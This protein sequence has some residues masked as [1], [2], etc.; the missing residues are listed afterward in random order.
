M[1]HLKKLTQ[2][3]AADPWGTYKR[4]ASIA[5]GVTFVGCTVTTVAGYSRINPITSP[6]I[7]AGTLLAK[8]AVAGALWPA[9]PIRMIV[10]PKSLF[11]VG[12][13]IT[14]I[15]NGIKA[16]LNEVDGAME[17]WAELKD[18]FTNSKT[19]EEFNVKVEKLNSS[20]NST[21]VKKSQ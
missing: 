1:E 10:D 20:K 13:S 5:F 6:E 7:F 14:K 19:I 18:I 8:C 15:E 21:P 2:R 17:H 12:S 16:E 9:T 3:V 11:I 4:A